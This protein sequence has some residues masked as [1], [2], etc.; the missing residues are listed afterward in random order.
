[1]QASFHWSQG[2]LIY[3]KGTIHYFLY[4]QLILVIGLRVV[5]RHY[6]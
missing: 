1:M 5:R 6:T 4:T 2:N 3:F